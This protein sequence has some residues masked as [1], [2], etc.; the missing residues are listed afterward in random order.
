MMM[1]SHSAAD[2]SLWMDD[3]SLSV[4]GSESLSKRERES[5]RERERES[6]RERERERGTQTDRRSLFPPSLFLSIHHLET[7]IQVATPQHPH[8]AGGASG[9]GI[10]G[11]RQSSTSPS[12]GA[13][14][15][16]AHV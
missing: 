15:K 1:L 9:H 8:S 11:L 14:E 6:E 5:E 12:R 4:G 3:T 2:S 16:A 7:H 10:I 13:S